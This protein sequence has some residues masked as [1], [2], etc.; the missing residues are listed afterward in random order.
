MSAAPI[1]PAALTTGVTCQAISPAPSLLPRKL[2]FCRSSERPARGLLVEG[3]QAAPHEDAVLVAQG[4]EVGYG[5]Q[6][7]EL[8]A[9]E[10]VRAEPVGLLEREGHEEVFE[11]VDLLEASPLE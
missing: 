5:A 11:D 9:L 7:D 4:H 6:G 3:R 2:A 8:E 10:I 1:R